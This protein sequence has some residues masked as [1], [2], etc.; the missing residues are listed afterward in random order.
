[1]VHWGSEDCVPP[2]PQDDTDAAWRD[3]FIAWA[4]VVGLSSIKTDNVEE[5][6]WRLTFLEETLGWEP[7]A[8]CFAAKKGHRKEWVTMPIIRRWVGLWANWSN[9]KRKEWVK[10]RMDQLTKACDL[11]VKLELRNAQEV[12]A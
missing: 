9:I 4:G 5:W 2:L 1:M 11:K 6:L 10:L 7:A 8:L 3:H 12:K